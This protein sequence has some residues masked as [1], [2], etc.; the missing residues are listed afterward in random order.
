MQPF[1]RKLSAEQYAVTQKNATTE[2]AFIMNTG[3]SIVPGIYVDITGE[4]LFVHR[5]VRF[6]LQ[7]A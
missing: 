3:M 5:Q 1:V 6:G 7:V 2:P 4:P